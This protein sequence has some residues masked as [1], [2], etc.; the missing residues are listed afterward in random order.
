MSQKKKK[1]N[2]MLIF[3]IMLGYALTYMDKNMI[4]TAIIPI[5]G[6]LSLDA[7]QSGLLMSMF[8]IGY[9]VMQFPSGWL[10][11]KIGPKKV[12]LISIGTIL[13][14]TIFFGFV[15]TLVLLMIIRLISGLGHAGVPTSSAKVVANNIQPKQKMFVQSLILSTSGIGGILAFTLGSTLI[16]MN[17]RYAYYGLAILYAV[18]ILMIFFF[19]PKEK[20]DTKVKQETKIPISV[21]FKDKNVFI[22]FTAL[23]FLNIVLYGYVS[24][25]PSFFGTNFGFDLKEISIILSI[26]AILMSVGALSSSFMVDKVFKGNNKLFALISVI[27]CALACI[28]FALAGG[29]V[30]SII[31]MF[32]F[33]LASNATFVTL[34]SWPHKLI[35]Q[36]VIGTSIAMINIG[37]T[38]G[39][40]LSPIITGYLITAFGGNFNVAFIAMGIS[41]FIC[42]LGILL[43]RTKPINTGEHKFV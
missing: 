12:L 25:L 15:S 4:A 29:L 6:E 26:N 1:N 8:F 34:F 37:S 21:V 18:S 7:S 32:I 40:F 17:W 13:I 3:S 28:I 27:V 30:V 23:L 19:F 24:W 35:K 39:G 31:M 14:A 9:T 22:L 10:S 43:V 11:D 41:A 2:V 42:G 33:T 38:F 16:N 20:K 5:E 36:E